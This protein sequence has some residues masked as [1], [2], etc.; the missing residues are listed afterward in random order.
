MSASDRNHSTQGLPG[1]QEKKRIGT[2]GSV[3]PKNEGRFMDSLGFAPIR[4]GIAAVIGV[5]NS[6]EG[7]IS[8]E[9][10]ARGASGRISR[11]MR[12]CRRK[13]GDTVAELRSATRM[14]AA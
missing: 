9:L 12:P 13:I 8:D 4:A 3:F 7:A 14:S 1:K 2:I 11:P 10:I 6:I 5:A